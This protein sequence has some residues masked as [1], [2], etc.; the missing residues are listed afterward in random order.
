[1]GLIPTSVEYLSDGFV[2]LQGAFKGQ[3]KARIPVYLPDRTVVGD[4]EV[5]ETDEGVFLT[6][7][8][9]SDLGGLVASEMV[10]LSVTYNSAEA[11]DTMAD[12]IEKD[13]N[14]E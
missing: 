11:R 6:M 3:S 4:A 14:N 5:F 2:V 13:S 10:G 7:S 9:G 1:M 8:I 12:A